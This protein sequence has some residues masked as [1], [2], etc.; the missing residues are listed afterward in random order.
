[1]DLDPTPATYQTQSQVLAGEVWLA[2]DDVR[3]AGIYI[4][5]QVAVVTLQA[6][7]LGLRF[8]AG[9]NADLV[10]LNARGAVA[11]WVNSLK[12]GDD[13]LVADMIRVL[14]TVNGLEVTGDEILSPA[15][16]VV[17]PVLGVLRSGIN[18]VVATSVQPDR[19]LQG[20]TNPDAVAY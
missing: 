15:G 7:T 3:A 18:L 12:P 10:A 16:D 9:A 6:V 8:L 5:I 13:L 4:Q 14:R 17:V 2:L 20:S 19:A 11:A 1:M